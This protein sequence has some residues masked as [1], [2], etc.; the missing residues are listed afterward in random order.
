MKVLVVHDSRAGVSNHPRPARLIRHT[1]S[2]TPA[3][4]SPA[5]TSANSHPSMMPFNHAITR[6]DAARSAP[7]PTQTSEARP[8]SATLNTPPRMISSNAS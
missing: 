4:D 1:P 7:T 6:T 2:Q 8:G 5:D 3:L